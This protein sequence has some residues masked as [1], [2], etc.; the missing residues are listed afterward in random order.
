MSDRGL[1]K[2]CGKHMRQPYHK[3]DPQRQEGGCRSC[4]V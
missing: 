2:D 4:D 3:H 1:Y